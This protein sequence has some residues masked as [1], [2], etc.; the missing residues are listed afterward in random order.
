MNSYVTFIPPKSRCFL[1]IGGDSGEIAET[2]KQIQPEAECS[3]IPVSIA[4]KNKQ[5]TTT[6]AI[7]CIFYHV[8][9][10]SYES[11]KKR[12]AADWQMLAKDGQIILMLSNYNCWDNLQK[13][14]AGSRELGTISIGIKELLELLNHIGWQIHQVITERNPK[15]KQLCEDAETTNLLA[16]FSAETDPLADAYVIRASKIKQE[17]NLQIASLPSDPVCERVRM[18]LPD[19][20]VQTDLQVEIQHTNL[21]D[22]FKQAEQQKLQHTVCVLERTIFSQ[23]EHVQSVFEVVAQQHNVVLHEIDDCPIRWQERFERT[24]YLEFVG[25]HAV[26][27][28]TPALRDYFL[29][30]NP[31]V[32]LFENQLDVLPPERKWQKDQEQVTIF[33]GALNRRDSWDDIMP[34]LN[35]LNREYGDRLCYKVTADREFFD[36]LQTRNKEYVGGE[37][38]EGEYAPYELYTE[39]LQTADIALLPLKDTMFNRMKSDLKFLECAAN[40]TVALASPTVYQNTIRDGRTGFL[41]RNAQEFSQWLRVLIEDET[42]R[43]ETAYLAYHYVKAHRMLSQH[44]EER[45]DAYRKLMRDWDRLERE[46]QQRVELRMRG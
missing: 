30:M 12:L 13:F 20:F 4:A 9:D 34:V 10:F 33:F 35:Q 2:F 28:S 29:E 24:K 15:E 45:I 8:D 7:D 21:E 25:C 16:Q 3:W 31:H 17:V 42:L 32:L 39:C 19:Q 22:L 11:L 1:E 5:L 43:R 14:F 38:N 40:G 44:Y 46:R 6:S 36:A 37:Y 26:Q 41:Y 23:P 27:T 18:I